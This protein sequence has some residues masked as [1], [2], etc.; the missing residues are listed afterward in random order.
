MTK[1]EFLNGKEFMYDVDLDTCYYF[2]NDTIIEAHYYKGEIFIRRH[3]ANV[4]NVGT[5]YFQYYNYILNKRV[6]GKINFLNL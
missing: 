6:S 3:H 2:E 1:Q 4:K 5:K